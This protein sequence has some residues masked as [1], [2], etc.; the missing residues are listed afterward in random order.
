[1]IYINY[2]CDKCIH[3]RKEKS[4]T[5]KYRPTCDAFP[6]EIPCEYFM[7]IDVTKIEE[8]NNGMKFEEKEDS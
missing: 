1:M 2:P 4:K 6:D 8:C 7:E 5:N 3:M